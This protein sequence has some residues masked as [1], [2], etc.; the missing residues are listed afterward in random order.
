MFKKQLP[1][2]A[3]LLIVL[4]FAIIGCKSKYDKLKLSNDN[5]KKFQEGKRLY[6]KKE[7]AKA[8][9]LF[10]TLLTRYRGTDGATDLFYL[11]AMANYKLKDYTAAAYHFNEFATSY[12]SD[13][14]AEEARFL[15]AYC[16]YL[17]AP[18]FSL[19]QEN[20]YKCIE[21]LQLFINLYPKSERVAEASK[22]IQDLRD[23]LELKAYS[24][25]KL[26]LTIGENQSAVIAF[27]NTLRDYPDTKY[28][29]E[30]EFLTIKAQ[31]EYA[32]QSR[33]YKQE[34]RY[35]QAIT[36]ADQFTDKYPKSIYLSQAQKLKK[37]SA[38]GI[39]DAKRI[40]AQANDNERLAR[41]LA[42][43]DSVFIQTRSETQDIHKKMP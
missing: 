36:F 2:F 13:P 41:K 30:L 20:T 33:E 32:H 21:K 8:L 3:G 14:R 22:L 42:R 24:N 29:E 34:E 5:A 28:A 37:D 17:D 35:T 23:R 18:G 9:G 7:Y 40:I 27:G 12:P 11:N 15:T 1:L 38:A 31:Y 25:A 4:L 16:Y 6:E 10:E 19:D 26:Y 43:K 39:Q